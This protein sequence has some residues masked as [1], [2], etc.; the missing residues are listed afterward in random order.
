MEEGKVN[1]KGHMSGTAESLMIGPSSELAAGGPGRW[2]WGPS[3][4]DSAFRGGLRMDK[5]LM[6]EPK[7]LSVTQRSHR[8]SP[9]VQRRS[10]RCCLTVT[11]NEGCLPGGR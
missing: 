8:N 2:S 1:K 11:P 10:A 7:V 5:E 6:A 3:P 9:E 4:E